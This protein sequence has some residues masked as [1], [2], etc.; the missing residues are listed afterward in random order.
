M[1]VVW[2]MCIGIVDV[3]YKMVLEQFLLLS[4]LL[5]SI[6]HCLLT[7]L[8]LLSVYGPI[9]FFVS[10]NDMII[11]CIVQEHVFPYVV[12]HLCCHLLHH[13]CH[14]K[15]HIQLP[16]LTGEEK[17]KR[18]NFKNYEG[19]K[20]VNCHCCDYDYCY[21]YYLYCAVKCNAIRALFHLWCISLKKTALL[22]CPIPS[23]EFHS[24]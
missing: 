7:C 1:T 3:M 14:L 8:P 2:Q 4:S 17:R 5:F 10:S 20:K 16:L 18:S 21:F 13:L 9:I 15:R 11:Y 12:R 24:Y 22:S 23:F 19:A 6:G